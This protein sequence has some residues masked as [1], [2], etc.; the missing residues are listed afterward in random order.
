M[1]VVLSGI[2]FKE[3]VSI[4]P[5]PSLPPSPL[6]PTFLSPGCHGV[7]SD[8]LSTIS[9]LVMLAVAVPTPD[10]FHG[11]SACRQSDRGFRFQ[12]R[13]FR[14]RDSTG[15]LCV[16]DERESVPTGLGLLVKNS[17]R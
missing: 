13:V 6:A 8:S 17:P 7:P 9:I 1:K 5:S 11:R 16:S 15:S 10:L 12:R 3:H 14:L 2:S 4:Q